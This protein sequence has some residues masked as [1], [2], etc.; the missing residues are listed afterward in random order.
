[1]EDT[2]H[3]DV[4]FTGEGKLPLKIISWFLLNVYFNIMP[5]CAF[6]THNLT[7]VYKIYISE[8]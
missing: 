6:P 3:I 4:V 1:M 5:W 2:W 8:N 7:A